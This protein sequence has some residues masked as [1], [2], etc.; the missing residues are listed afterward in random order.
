MVYIPLHHQ[1]RALQAACNC[2]ITR[3]PPTAEGGPP[4]GQRRL[5]VWYC[6]RQVQVTQSS[7]TRTHGHTHHFQF[8]LM[9]TRSG[10][11]THFTPGSGSCVPLW[12][13]FACSH[14]QSASLWP[15]CIHPFI[16]NSTGC[17]WELGGGGRRVVVV[18]EAQHCPHP[19]SHASMHRFSY[20]HI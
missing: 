7:F 16:S 18:G 17:G 8:M 4:Q 10:P 9:M 19:N 6:W 15:P 14:T 20:T 5:S 12:T 11:P 1:R 3:P 13:W 2:L